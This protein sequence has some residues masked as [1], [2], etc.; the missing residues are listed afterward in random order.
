MNSRRGSARP[1]SPARM[2]L[3]KTTSTRASLQF[4]DTK[5]DD[6]GLGGRDTRWCNTEGADAGLARGK[7]LPQAPRAL[8]GLRWHPSGCCPS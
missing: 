6:K 8:Q 1:G 2:A 5:C 7:L 3:R 4:N